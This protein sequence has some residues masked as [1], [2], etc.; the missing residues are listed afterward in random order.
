[1]AA[2]AQNAEDW[3]TQLRSGVKLCVFVNALKPGIVKR[4]SDS[5]KPF[6]QRAHGLSVCFPQLLHQCNGWWQCVYSLWWLAGRTLTD[7]PHVDG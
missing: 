7:S 2:P 3:I 1:M 5:E 4:I 6:P